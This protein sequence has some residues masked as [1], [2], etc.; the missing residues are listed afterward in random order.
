MVA[1]ILT[2]PPD[3]TSLSDPS[4]IKEVSERGLGRRGFTMDFTAQLDV[5][6]V[7]LEAEDINL[8]SRGRDDKE[9]RTRSRNKRDF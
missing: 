5:D 1:V 2:D 6:V 7:A 8:T 9:R 3:T 4:G